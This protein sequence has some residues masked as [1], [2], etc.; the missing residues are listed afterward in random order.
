MA[1]K[2]LTNGGH[3]GTRA[4]E[5]WGDIVFMI[6]NL[7][8][9]RYGEVATAAPDF[10]GM[11]I[12]NDEALLCPIGSIVE[13]EKTSHLITW[14]ADFIKPVINGTEESAAYTIRNFPNSCEEWVNDRKN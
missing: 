2:S 10:S 7:L 13:R 3:R 8:G 12:E 5:T 14:I 1:E 6:S 4:N 9:K 11:Q